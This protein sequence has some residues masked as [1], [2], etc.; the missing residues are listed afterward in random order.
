LRFP[1]NGIYVIIGY[2]PRQRVAEDIIHRV[3]ELPGFCHF[4]I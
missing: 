1:I 4:N 2:D 3:F